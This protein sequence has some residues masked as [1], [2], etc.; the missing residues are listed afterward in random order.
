MKTLDRSNSSGELG[1]DTLIDQYSYYL[2]WYYL[3][4]LS[5]LDPE[6][7][8]CNM[9]GGRTEYLGNVKPEIRFNDKYIHYSCSLIPY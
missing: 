9:I 8:Q 7:N 6:A 4:H 2:F 3:F 1:N 5:D